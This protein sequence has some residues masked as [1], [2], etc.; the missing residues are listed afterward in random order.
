MQGLIKFTLK[1]IENENN[2]NTG[3]HRIFLK[4]TFKF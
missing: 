3:K 4:S 2:N 1:I